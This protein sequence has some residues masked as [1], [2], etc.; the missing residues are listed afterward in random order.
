[1]TSKTTIPCDFHMHTEFSADSQAPVT[2]MIEQ[3]IKKG[4]SAICITDHL[5]FDYLADNQQSFELDG[6]SYYKTLSR[7]SMEYA[8]VIRILIGVETGLEPDKADMLDDFIQKHPYD[9]I[10]GS[11]HLI[12]RAD[13]YYPEFFYNRP[14]TEVFTEY[15]ES[16]IE[17]LNVCNNFDVYGHIDYV[18]RYSPNKAKNYSYQKYSDILDEILKKLIYSGKGIEVN[19]GGYR[20]GLDFPNPHPDII[21]RYREF[22]GE[23]ITVGSDA[24]TPECI[25]D[26]FNRVVGLLEECGYKYYTIFQ[27][28]KPAFVKL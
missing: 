3:A 27:E 8:D 14:D 21:K 19:T 16:I 10:I 15:F 22:G 1:M 5:D 17:N 26:E 23:I 6:D 9:F 20:S 4:L 13:P 2:V 24:H 11:S 28:R 7:L 25:A 18:V 12:H